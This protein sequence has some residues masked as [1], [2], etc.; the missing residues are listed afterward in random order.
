MAQEKLAAWLIPGIVGG[1]TSLVTGAASGFAPGG[2]PA[3]GASP[4]AWAPMGGGVNM[5]GQ[6]VAPPPAPPKPPPTTDWAAVLI[7][8]ALIGVGLVAVIGLWKWAMKPSAPTR[9]W[10][11]R[12]RT[13]RA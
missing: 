3:A 6:P 2:V 13:R 9:R 7:P 11:T 10:T 12:R 1:V 5:F 8:V 4:T